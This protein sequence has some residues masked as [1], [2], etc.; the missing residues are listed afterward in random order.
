MRSVTRSAPS[1][2]LPLPT[3]Q[4]Q[5]P[6]LAPALVGETGWLRT[7]GDAPA[8]ECHCEERSDEAISVATRLL[9]FARDDQAKIFRRHESRPRAGDREPAPDGARCSGRSR[10]GRVAIRVMRSR[11]RAAFG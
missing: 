8:P 3:P 7:A 6:A 9:R 11:R 1:F 5:A 10:R 4:F 2:S